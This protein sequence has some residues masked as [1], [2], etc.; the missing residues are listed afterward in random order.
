MV[1]VSSKI[2]QNH[3][4][5]APNNSANLQGTGTFKDCRIQLGT[6]TIQ[7]EKEYEAPG[8][9]CSSFNVFCYS[10]LQYKALL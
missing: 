6:F 3:N 1:D 9:T 8:N 7:I 4:V 2:H 5:S 10:K